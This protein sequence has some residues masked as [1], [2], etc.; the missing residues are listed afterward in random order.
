MVL[1]VFRCTFIL[2]WCQTVLQFLPFYIAG[3]HRVWHGSADILIGRVAVVAPTQLADDN[4]ENKTYSS[5]LEPS[6]NQIIATAIAF[7]FT[8]NRG[9]VPTIAFSNETFKIFMYDP[10]HDLLFEGSELNLFID[11]P[12]LQRSLLQFDT[13]T[14]F[15]LWLV[16]NYDLFCSGVSRDHIEFGYFANFRSHVKESLEIYKHDMTFGRFR[17]GKAVELPYKAVKDSWERCC[18]SNT[19]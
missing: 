11:K 9:L 17:P 15:A 2:Q 12:P 18:Y 19:I 14:I 4:T 10:E 3:N 6:R 8:L 7:A 1:Q 5:T 13:R 16:V